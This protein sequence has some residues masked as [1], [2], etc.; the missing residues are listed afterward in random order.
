MTLGGNVRKG[1]LPFMGK[2][3]HINLMIECAKMIR[4]HSLYPQ[5]SVKAPEQVPL[6]TIAHVHIVCGGKL[7]T[8]ET[9]KFNIVFV[10]IVPTFDKIRKAVEQAGSRLSHTKQ[11][12]PFIAKISFTNNAIFPSSLPIYFISTLYKCTTTI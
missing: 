2:M 7:T 11:V 10:G 4:A 12:K 6:M 1:R 5:L 3:I 8:K 9:K